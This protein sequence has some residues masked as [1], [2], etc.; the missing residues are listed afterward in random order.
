V[1]ER[2]VGVTVLGFLAAV[3]AILNILRGLIWLGVG[4]VLAL[5]MAVVHPI[6]GAMVGLF[7]LIFG[8]LA[9][10]SG[11]VSL[12]VAWGVFNLKRWAWTWGNLT[13]WGI[14]IWSLL[15][16]IGPSTLRMQAAALITSGAVLYYLHRPAVKAAFGKA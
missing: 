4:G 8:G 15:A 3:S 2:P 13:H 5:G 14:V 16:A 11:I 1:A 7:A 12:F 6:A 10:L 9:L